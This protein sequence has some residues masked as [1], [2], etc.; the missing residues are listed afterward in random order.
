MITAPFGPQITQNGQRRRL[1]DPGNAIAAAAPV[2]GL[3]RRGVA[4]R[5]QRE[6]RP[7]HCWVQRKNVGKPRENWWVYHSLPTKMVNQG[8]NVGKPRETREFTNQNGDLTNRRLG[9]TKGKSS[10]ENLVMENQG[11]LYFTGH[12]ICWNWGQPVCI[13]PD[14]TH[15]SFDK[16]WFST[17][18]TA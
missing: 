5:R 7:K 3:E 4:A 10:R 6:T 8:E 11:K 17:E 16:P 12:D 15:G 14:K 1:G 13:K 2:S 18:G 9:S